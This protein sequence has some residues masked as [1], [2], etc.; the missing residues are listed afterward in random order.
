VGVAVEDGAFATFFLLVWG[1][2]RWDVDGMDGGR[3]KD[4]GEATYVV[5]HE[6]DGDAGVVGPLWFEAFFAEA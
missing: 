1:R 4:G 5:K 2:V 3:E 6:G